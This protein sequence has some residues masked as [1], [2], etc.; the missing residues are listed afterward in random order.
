MWFC[1][2]N[3]SGENISNCKKRDKYKKDYV[4]YIISKSDHGSKHLITKLQHDMPVSLDNT[5][6]NVISTSAGVNKGKHIV[7]YNIWSKK[8]NLMQQH[9][10]SDLLIEISYINKQGD[11]ESTRR[12]ICGGEFES[13]IHVMKTRKKKTFVYDA[14]TKNSF[15]INNCNQ[16][17]QDNYLSLNN[18]IQTFTQDSNTSWSTHHNQPFL[19]NTTN[20]NG[21]EFSNNPTRYFSL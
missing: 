7:I 9:L 14:T 2:S 12:T 8:Q 15:I 6:E 11:I 1:G 21:N 13:M 17:S 18:E 3:E 5:P 20:E 4:E 16:L 19:F 10:I